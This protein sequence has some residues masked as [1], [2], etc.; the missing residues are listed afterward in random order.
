[1][2]TSVMPVLASPAAIPDQVVTLTFG[3][4]W[5]VLLFAASLAL[6]CGLM[7]LLK[8]VEHDTHSGHADHFPLTLV[9]PV[10]HRA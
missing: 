2:L 10:G 3:P 6:T 4:M 5:T 7:W 9:R 1:M 8:N